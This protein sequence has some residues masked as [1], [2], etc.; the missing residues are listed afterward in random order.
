MVYLAVEYKYHEI[1]IFRLPRGN[2]CAIMVKDFGLVE[3]GQI[4]LHYSPSDIGELKFPSSIWIL[5]V[6]WHIMLLY[7]IISLEKIL[8]VTV[9]LKR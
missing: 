8:V 3:T 5:R 6:L 2:Y 9:A 4:Y 7:Y 1:L